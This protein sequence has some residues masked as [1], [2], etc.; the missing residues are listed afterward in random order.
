M[1]F[2]FS[3]N[4]R[5]ALASSITNSDL[6]LVLGA[7]QGA[8]FP[9]PAGGD[10]FLVTLQDA[11]G[12][13]EIMTCTARSADLLTVARGAEGTTPRAFITGVPVGIRLT[14]GQL[15]S[16]AAKARNLA[17]LPDPV[18]ARTSLGLGA[19]ALAAD[20]KYNHRNNNLSDVPNK[21]TARVNLELVIGQ[22]V[23]ANNAQLTQLAALARTLNGVIIGDGTNWVVKS[24]STLREAL[25]LGSVATRN[26][27]ISA[28]PPTGGSDGDIWF[29]RE[30]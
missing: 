20:D 2:L 26:L 4:A 10:T 24:G 15:G 13:L 16:F 8:L 9:N 28:A 19:A 14:A 22:H 17:D 29:T 30:A 18:A 12:N 25:G 11:A 27:T 5:G 21:A 7:G 23:Q 1:V 3:N 6:Q